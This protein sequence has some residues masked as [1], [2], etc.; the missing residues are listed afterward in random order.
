MTQPG[1]QAPPHRP[2]SPQL[3]ALGGSQTGGWRGTPGC[4]TWRLQAVQLCFPGKEEGAVNSSSWVLPR[5]QGVVSK[6]TVLSLSHP[7]SQ[8]RWV[9]RL[10]SC[11]KRACRL[12]GPSV[13]LPSFPCSFPESWPDFEQEAYFSDALREAP[14]KAQTFMGSAGLRNQGFGG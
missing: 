9:D 5:G 3:G 8:K 7:S 13:F 12:P 4:Q 2:R 10:S 1:R 11:R 14:G 6:G